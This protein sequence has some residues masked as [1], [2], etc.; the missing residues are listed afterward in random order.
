MTH[1]EIRYYDLKEEIATMQAKIRGASAEEWE[2]EILRDTI[3]A[4]TNKVEKL[5]AIYGF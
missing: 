3:K 5:A 1:Q 2:R 4:Y